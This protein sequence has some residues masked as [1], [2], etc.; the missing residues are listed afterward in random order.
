MTI[1]YNMVDDKLLQ[2]I[3]SNKNFIWS[4]EFIENNEIHLR[5]FIP[6]SHISI[7]FDET[8]SRNEYMVE[9]FFTKFIRTE[10]EGT[11]KIT[12]QERSSICYEGHVTI[13]QT[14]KKTYIEKIESL[15][16]EL[17]GSNFVE[18]Y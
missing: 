15:I 7:D 14:D 16:R 13:P 10:Y 1:D 11:I 2:E 12:V 6:Q 5:M 17:K 3:L 18:G 9:S 8:R 4:H